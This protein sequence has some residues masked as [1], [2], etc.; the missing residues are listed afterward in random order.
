MAKYEITGPDGAKYEVTAP[1]NASEQDVLSYFQANISKPP[2]NSRVAINAVNRAI[3]GV[4]DALLNTPQNLINLGKAGFGAAATAMGRP[5][6]APNISEPPNF[7]TKG[8]EKAGFIDPAFDPQ[9]QG[10]RILA[11]VAGGATAAAM[12]PARSVTQALGNMAVGGASGLTSA[13]TKE[14]TGSDTAAMAAGLLTPMAMQNIGQGGQRIAN[15]IQK[16]QLDNQVR[17]QVLKTAQDRGYVVEPSSVNPSATNNILGSIAGKAATKQEATLRNQPLTTDAAKSELRF[18][19]DRPITRETLNDFREQVAWPYREASAIS[20]TGAATVERLKEA[21][22]E[23]RLQEN[24]FQRT[25]DPD[26]KKK[27]DGFKKLEQAYEARLQKIVSQAGKPDLVKDL[28]ASRQE[29]AKSYSIED[30][31]NMGDS[32]ISA[33]DLGR[34]LARGEP[35]SGKLKDVAQFALGPGRRVTGEESATPPADVSAVKPLAGAMMASSGSP[36][37][38]FAAGI[39][40]LGGPVR[41]LILSPEYQALM[42]KP[43]YDVPLTAKARA[44]M[45]QGMP[46]DE[47]MRI[48]LTNQGLLGK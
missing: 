26:A 7:I 33:Q 5:D 29:I 36:A 38:L 27:A 20:K 11:S 35:L 42:A 12:S 21:R 46:E 25:G 1:D 37:G 9:T 47:L 15:E 28:K 2:S 43:K 13:A 30:A 14:A 4:P 32:Q 22:Y 18:P 3:A 24:F 23:R 19:A 41:N 6:M 39:P 45:V 40:F 17:D 10:Q 16:R 44:S 48:L 31:L 8:F 34:Q